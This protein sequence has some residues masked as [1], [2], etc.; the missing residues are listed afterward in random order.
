VPVSSCHPATP[1]VCHRE[2]I[3]SHYYGSHAKLNPFG[4]IPVGDAKW[5]AWATPHGRE[6]LGE[7]AAGK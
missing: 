1:R 6:A 3:K 4:I 5:T 7:D 2:H